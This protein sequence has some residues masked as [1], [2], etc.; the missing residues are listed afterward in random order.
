M[1]GS[2]TFTKFLS[3]ADKIDLLLSVNPQTCA[4]LVCRLVQSGSGKTLA[5]FS[6]LVCFLDHSVKLFGWH[7]PSAVISPARFV[8][9]LGLM[10]VV[11]WAVKM[12]V[13]ILQRKLTLDRIAMYRGY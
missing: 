9:T 12:T 5:H 2:E 1:N 6:R 8:V 4:W 10:C 3:V 7:T 13:R 11:Q